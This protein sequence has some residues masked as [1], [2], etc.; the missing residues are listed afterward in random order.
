MII[1]PSSHSRAPSR[2]PSPMS[3]VRIPD[4]PLPFAQASPNSSDF[5]IEHATR[6]PRRQH[7]LSMPLP[8]GYDGEMVYRDHVSQLLAAKNTVFSVSGRIP[9]DPSQLVLFF[10]TKV[11]ADLPHLD[12]L[13]HLFVEWYNALSGLSDRCRLQ[14]TTC[15]RRPNRSVPPAPNVRPRFIRRAGIPLLPT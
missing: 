9:L 1:A 8:T 15:T 10:R 14:H 12:H 13:I 6:T 5:H 2:V 4:P 11:L 7:S 3:Y